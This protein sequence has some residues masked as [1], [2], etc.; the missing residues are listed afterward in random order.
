MTTEKQNDM[1]ATAEKT[2]AGEIERRNEERLARHEWAAWQAVCASL[3]L[4]GAV[5]GED[6]TT[7]VAAL[8]SGRALTRGTELLD[9]LR[10]WG[11]LRELQGANE[12]QRKVWQAIDAIFRKEDQDGPRS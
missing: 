12:Q 6:L 3:R 5:T 1:T 4:A 11:R 2:A 7:P 9:L 10:R 8:A